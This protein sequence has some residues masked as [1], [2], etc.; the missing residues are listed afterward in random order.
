MKS[1]AESRDADVVEKLL[2]FFVDN[3]NKECFAACL[4]TCYD[5]VRPDVVMELAWK[6]GY[7]DFAMPYFIQV[8]KEYTSKV[9]QLTKENTEKEEEEPAA[10]V[11]QFPSVVVGEPVYGFG[12]M[13]QVGIPVGMP[14]MSMGMGGVPLTMPMGGMPPMGMVPVGMPPGSGPIMGYSSGAPLSG[15]GHSGFGFM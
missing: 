8:I 2:R 1:A 13:Q 4:Y 6:H 10:P 3:Q 9:D 15:G 11:T 7:T 5:F 12:G 14:P